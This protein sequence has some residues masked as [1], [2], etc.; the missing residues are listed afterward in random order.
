MSAFS[1]ALPPPV[2]A[3]VCRVLDLLDMA[4]GLVCRGVVLVAG[5]ALLGSITIGVVLRYVLSR[6]GVDWAEEL[7]KQMFAW[8]IMAGV[9]LAM[10][11]G[12]HLAVDLLPQSL[13]PKPRQRLL[14]AI[15]VLVA[16]AY[17]WLASTAF[18]VAGVAAAEIN[19]VLGTPGSLGYYALAGG[20]VLA[21]VAATIIAVRVALLGADAAPVFASEEAVT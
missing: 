18:E 6:G 16:I 19:P 11:R 1:L 5:L 17:G 10:Q 2:R 15:N 3:A 9:V 20:S 7:P 21:A 14:V 4:I 13:P 8:F 12:S